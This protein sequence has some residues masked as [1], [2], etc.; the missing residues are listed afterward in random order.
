MALLIERN[1]LAYVF[2]CPDPIAGY[3]YAMFFEMVAYRFSVAT[4]FPSKNV[5]ALPVLIGAYDLSNLVLA[6]MLLGLSHL[7]YHCFAI[8]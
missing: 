3:L 1:H 8:I 4:V 6:E 2:L 7:P 5:C